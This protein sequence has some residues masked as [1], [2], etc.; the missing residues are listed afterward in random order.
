MKIFAMLAAVAALSVGTLAADKNTL[1]NVS[2][3]VARELYE[4]YNAL[5]IAEHKKKSGQAVKINQ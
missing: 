3:D 2:Y 1:L 5:F 4:E